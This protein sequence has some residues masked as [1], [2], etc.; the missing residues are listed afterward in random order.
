M[1]N[2]DVGGAVKGDH[3]AFKL[4]TES[5]FDGKYTPNREIFIAVSFHGRHPS[6]SLCLFS[7]ACE[8]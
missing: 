7:L 6:V 1:K 4:F 8:L 2:K 3:L 5:G